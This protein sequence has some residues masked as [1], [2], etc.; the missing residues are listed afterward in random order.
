MC[1]TTIDTSTGM[2]IS[3]LT[4]EAFDEIQ[5]VQVGTVL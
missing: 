5:Q 2:V 4:T 3:I 1:C